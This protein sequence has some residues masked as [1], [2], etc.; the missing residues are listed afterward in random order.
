M[1]TSNVPDKSE[2][3]MLDQAAGK[4]RDTSKSDRILQRFRQR[5]FKSKRKRQ[6]FSGT[7]DT[8]VAELFPLFCPA[9]EADWIPGWDSDLIYT[10]SGLVEDNC[11]FKTDKSNAAGDGLWMFIG[12]E[13]NHYVEFV[14]I[15]ADIISRGRVTVNDNNDGTV[16]ATWNILYTGLTEKGNQEIDKLPEK[17]PPQADAL[18]KMIDFYLKKGKTINR[19]SLA[20]GTLAGHMGTHLS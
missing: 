7:W 14:R 5:N 8:T 3:Q 9:R 20:A 6:E 12:Y 19:A 13:V 17:N 15:Q 1:N 2:V 11:L 18:V 16:S 4:K 10:D